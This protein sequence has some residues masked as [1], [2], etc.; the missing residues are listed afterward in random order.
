MLFATATAAHATVVTGISDQHIATWGGATSAWLRGLTRV[1]QARFIVDWN[2]ALDTNGSRFRD[3]S[4]WLARVETLGLTPIISFSRTPRVPLPATTADYERAVRAF[5]AAFPNVTEYTAWNE[6]NHSGTTT[7]GAERAATYWNTLNAVC[8]TPSSTGKRCTVAAGDFAD[9]AG[10]PGYLSTYKTFLNATPSVWALHLYGAI[11]YGDGTHLESFLARTGS[12]P[13]WITEVGGLVCRRDANGNQ[14]VTN[15]L[16]V[17]RLQAINLLSFGRAYESRIRRI[18]YYQLA[19]AY[20][21]G[22]CPGAG[23]F[24]TYLLSEG[25][26]ERPALRVIRNGV[27]LPFLFEN[28]QWLMRFSFTTGAADRQFAWPIPGGYQP[29]D[30]PLMGDW[31][32]DGIETP[33]I[34]RGNL[35]Y[36]YSTNNPWGTVSGFI[37]GDP[38][39]HAIVGDWNGDGVDS[40]ALQRGNIFYVS[41]VNATGGGGGYTLQYGDA[42]DVGVGGDWNG[43][44]VDT[45]GIVRGNVWYLLNGRTNTS[46]GEAFIY[47]NGGDIPVTGDWDGDGRDDP[48]VFRN[49]AWYLSYDHA[50]VGNG[51]S[52]DFGSSNYAPLIGG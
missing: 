49:G 32:G 8:Q 51:V 39:D 17:Q 21:E 22:D 37:L 19:P 11:E 16:E 38:G 52:F 25:Q 2:A 30:E 45:L 24:D 35:F 34:H 31:D 13:V 20:G 47:G 48:G 7:D 44:G 33:G 40:I 26:W 14:T 3:A 9:G 43:D 36:L 12:A 28:G 41:D 5:R 6:P 1:R 50:P 42:G 15:S 29:G 23:A 4:A 27:P 18:Y 46:P 10:M